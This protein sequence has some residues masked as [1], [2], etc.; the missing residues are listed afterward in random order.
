MG[1]TSKERVMT[2]FN[3]QEADRVPVWLGA[4]PEFRTLI[5]NQLGLGDDES[6]S[7]YL[8]DDF[9]RVF[10]RYTGPEER[11]PGANLT[12]PD[13]TCRTPF[14]VQRLWLWDATESPAGEHRN[15]QRDS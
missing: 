2:A 14:D 10:A 1:M 12:F 3:H 13:A 9:R 5:R 4:S 15:R 8:R 6:L 7:V 11:S